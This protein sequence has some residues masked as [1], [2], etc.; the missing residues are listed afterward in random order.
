M[1][2]VDLILA[3]CMIREPST[4]R[5]E[6][7]YFESHGSLSRCMIEAVPT[8]AKWAADHPEWRIARFHCEWVDTSEERT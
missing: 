2:I 5:E 3:V 1:P 6:H 8:L 7:L 4:C